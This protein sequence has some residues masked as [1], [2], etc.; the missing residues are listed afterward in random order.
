MTPL[1]IAEWTHAI[2]LHVFR[3]DLS[4]N[5]AD[6]LLQEFQGHRSQNLWWQVPLPDQAFEVCVQLAQQHAARLGVR[7]LDTLQVASAIELKAQHFWT[8]DDRQAKLAAAV[9]LKTS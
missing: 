8:F 7:T 2:E 9:G 6:R 3:K 1:H 5:D 4:R